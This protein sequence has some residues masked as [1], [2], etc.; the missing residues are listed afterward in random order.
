MCSLLGQRFNRWG[1]RREGDVS[2]E[3]RSPN[4]S[5]GGGLAWWLVG[6]GE[7]DSLVVV[8]I[9]RPG[10]VDRSIHDSLE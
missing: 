6:I 10:K 7:A 3:A 5:V 4:R 2:N 8:S 9:R 1:E